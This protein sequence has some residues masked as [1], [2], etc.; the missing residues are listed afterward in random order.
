MTGHDHYT[1]ATFVF[2]D[3]SL[4][5][6]RTCTFTETS[7]N[8][9][10]FFMTVQVHKIELQMIH[11]FHTLLESTVSFRRKSKSENF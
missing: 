9:N 4:S 3:K 5:C 8:G 7:N 2:I 1:L 10:N 11:L 6:T